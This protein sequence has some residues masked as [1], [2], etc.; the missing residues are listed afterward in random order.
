MILLEQVSKRFSSG[1]GEK[2]AIEKQIVPL[3]QRINEINAE[4]TKAR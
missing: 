1:K 2:T 4:L 3:R